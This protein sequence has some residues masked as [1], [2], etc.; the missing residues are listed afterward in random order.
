MHI[1]GGYCLPT[2][3]ASNDRAWLAHSHLS[4]LAQLLNPIAGEVQS[5]QLAAELL[6]MQEEASNAKTLREELKAQW[7]GCRM[8]AGNSRV[9]SMR[10]TV[11][12]RGEIG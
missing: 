7:L 8:G 12:Y 10:Q 4:S 1:V 6:E 11:A 2:H 3:A 5:A 9:D